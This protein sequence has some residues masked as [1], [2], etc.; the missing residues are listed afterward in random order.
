MVWS[1]RGHEPRLRPQQVQRRNRKG[2]VP[3]R[4]FNRPWAPYCRM[5]KVRNETSDYGRPRDA[6]L[7]E[8]WIRI[9]GTSCGCFFRVIVLSSPDFQ[10]R[11]RIRSRR[12]NRRIV[13]L[14]SGWFSSFRRPIPSPGHRSLHRIW[15]TWARRKKGFRSSRIY[16]SLKYFF[17]GFQ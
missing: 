8:V 12:T 14:S 17:R 13:V 2:Q 5:S 9:Q 11:P 10:S 7:L 6:T 3:A 4:G 16:F 15:D 1:R